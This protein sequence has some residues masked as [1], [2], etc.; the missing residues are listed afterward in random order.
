MIMNTF[1][2]FFPQYAGKITDTTNDQESAFIQYCKVFSSLTTD[3]FYVF[4]V[5]QKQFCYIKP[6]DLFLCGYSVEEAM[7]LGRNLHSQIVH[8]EDLPLWTRIF[9][10]V[11]QYLKE[12]QNETNYF[13]CTFRLLHK[14]RSVSKPLPLMVYQ[15]IKPIYINDR[16]LYMACTIECS[17]FNKSGN[18]CLHNTEGKVY[19][20]YN[21]KTRR[22]EQT[23]Q[24]YISEC[25]KTILLLAKQGKN[26]REIAALLYK[27][28][29][30]IQNQ[31]NNLFQKLGVHSMREAIEFVDHYG[32]Y[33]L[34]SS[35]TPSAKRK[36]SL[37]NNKLQ[38]IQQLLN[39]HEGIRAIARLEDIPESS[40]R[41]WIGKGIL[42]RK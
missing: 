20:A 14:Y 3:S 41:Y 1:E 27:G 8:P 18:L 11:L 23:Q 31:T 39:S 10:I 19:K 2:D 6:H 36:V 5:V 13:S 17:T 32:L 38:R 35:P 26:S 15:Q 28:R 29:N 9:E 12:N 7:K 24:T 22:W 34:H 42:I 30:T 21:I 37:S 40:I 33:S 4:D 16:F 25:E